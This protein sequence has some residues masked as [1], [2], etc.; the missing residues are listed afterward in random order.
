MGFL[1]IPALAFAL[2]ALPILLLYM[3]KLRRQEVRVSSILLWQRLLRDREA[4]T[5]WQRLRRN[6]LLLLQLLALA[7]LVVALARPFLPT[8]A[9]VSG[10][11]V[12][13]LDGSASMQAT[14]GEPT[15]FE[16]ARRAAR[17]I[18]EGLAPGDRA[19]LV[20]VGPQPQVLAGPS[21]DRTALLRA[22]EGAA[23]SDGLADW[24]TALET[25]AALTAGMDAPHYLI[26]S[27]GGLPAEL[28]G[29]PGEVRYLRVGDRDDNLG[30]LALSVR[31]GPTG[32]Q[33]FLRVGNFGYAPAETD[34]AIRTD[35]QLFDVR[36]V[37]I[38]PR[39]QVG[40][41]LED[42]PYDLRVLEVR[43]EKEDP[44]GVDNVAWAVRSGGDRRR[45]LLITPG[46]L[47]LE[48]ALASLPDVELARLSPD[49]PL[50]QEPYDLLVCDG[51]ITATLPAGNLWVIG[52]YGGASGVFTDTRITRVEQGHPVLRY[53]EWRDVHVMRAWRV[54]PPPG[55]RVLVE[56]E[57]GPLLLVA[58]RPDGRLAVL[59]F[60]LHESDLPL[61]V[62][63]PILVA[64]LSGWLLRTGSAAATASLPPGALLPVRADPHAERIEVVGPDGA[65]WSPLAPLDRVGL[66]RVDHIAADRTVLRS[67][68]FAVNLFDETESDIAPRGR[69]T[70]G[71]AAVAAG[72]AQEE[73]RRE[74]WPWLAGLGLGVIGVEWWAYHRGPRREA[75]GGL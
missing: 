46:N 61:R 47:F 43:L 33:G 72:P 41:A 65:P 54:D 31:D 16:A 39:G 50:P 34:L 53:V 73:G 4:N 75:R 30:I 2:L 6:L 37:T 12:L 27:D 28:P 49:Q 67:D 38:P 40:I 23:P 35:G 57:G 8:R 7:L 1:N 62:A 56:A 17:E 21:E 24:Q 36:R 69:L 45:I 15:R 19:A 29:L 63:F 10:S 55:A 5:P 52:P 60:D 26:I 3:L 20:L 9:P 48:R 14:D 51:P 66:Y 11:V 74:L 71:G 44:L 68:L 22:L 58:D 32:P 64:N 70:I 25:A 18:L 59:T 13:L 42:L